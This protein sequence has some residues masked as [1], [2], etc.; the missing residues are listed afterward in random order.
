MSLYFVQCD[1][2]IINILSEKETCHIHKHTKAVRWLVLSQSQWIGQAIH[3]FKLEF[4]LTRVL[5]KLNHSAFQMK[6]K[7]S[8]P[9]S[10]DISSDSRHNQDESRSH[11][12]VYYFGV[13]CNVIFI[14]MPETSKLFLHFRFSDKTV[15]ISHCSS[16]HHILTAAPWLH[17]PNSQMRIHL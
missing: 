7:G 17:L 15:H 4:L 6:P 2:T 11:P 8:L 12:P 14:S 13:N 10:T 3:W 9:C 1:N 16:M 5:E